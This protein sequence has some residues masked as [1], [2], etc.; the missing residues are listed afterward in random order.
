M[1]K[2]L[3]FPVSIGA[4]RGYVTYLAVNNKLN[5][6]ELTATPNRHQEGDVLY[7]ISFAIDGDVN[8]RYGSQEIA[9]YG[10]FFQMQIHSSRMVLTGYSLIYVNTLNIHPCFPYF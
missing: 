7:N 10:Q 1:T 9:T 4:N 2:T 6:I 3:Q 5:L 8:T